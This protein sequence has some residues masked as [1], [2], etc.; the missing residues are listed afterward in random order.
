MMLAQSTAFSPFTIG[1][2]CER[3]Y[4]LTQEFTGIGEAHND[5]GEPA[6]G[7]GSAWRGGGRSRAGEGLPWSGRGRAAPGGSEE[8]PPRRSGPRA[9]P[10]HVP[11]RAARLGGDE[12]APGGLEAQDI[13]L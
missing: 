12:Y 7:K 13:A 8:G 3:C 6:K 1:A 10:V 11:P 4:K 2:F 9:A 5:G